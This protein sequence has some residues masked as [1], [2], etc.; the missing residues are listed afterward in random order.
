[1]KYIDIEEYAKAGLPTPKGDKYLIK[2]DKG[3][4]KVESECMTGR[5]ILELAEK[6]HERFQCN[7]LYNGGLIKKVEY[8]ER[9]YFSRHGLERFMTMPLDQTQG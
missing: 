1:M 3:F 4:Y 5:E 9:V 2:I 8:D 6:K 7:V